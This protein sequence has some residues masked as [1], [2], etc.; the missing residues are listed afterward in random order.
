MGVCDGKHFG[1][2]GRQV[3]DFS[4]QCP[5]NLSP[6]CSDQFPPDTSRRSQKAVPV[7][8][9]ASHAD[10]AIV[11]HPPLIDLLIFA[12]FEPDHRVFILFYRDIATRG[13]MSAN[14]VGFFQFPDTSLE[15]EFS[16]R[17]TTYRTNIGHVSLKFIGHRTVG[18]RI[19]CQLVTPVE[20]TKLMG[21]R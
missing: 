15:A 8:F 13:A 5:V 19:D 6:G 14:R 10:A 4:L 9:E 12:G 2:D 17:D 16:F 20:H 21:A 18:E 1:C 3:V 7:I 11:T